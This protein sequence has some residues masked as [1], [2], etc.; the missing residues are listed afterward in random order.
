MIKPGMVS[1]SPTLRHRSNRGATREITGKNDTAR[2]TS[3]IIFLPGKSSRAIAYA[4]NVARTTLITVAI[5]HTMI[6]L[7]R[8]GRNRSLAPPVRISWKF[9]QVI[10]RGKYLLSAWI[11]LGFTASEKIQN[12]GINV[13]SMTGIE[14][15]NRLHFCFGVASMSLLLYFFDPAR[16]TLNPLMKIRAMANTMRNRTTDKAD[17]IPI[18]T[19]SMVCL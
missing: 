4:Q 16:S 8:A 12:I 2:D 17:P 11:E 15:A 14:T 6:E 3:R 1:N 13:H 9:S 7:R 19:L 5:R 18:S 10:S